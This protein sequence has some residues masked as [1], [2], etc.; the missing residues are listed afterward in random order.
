MLASIRRWNSGAPLGELDSSAVTLSLLW[1]N[2]AGVS[3][4]AEA[5]TQ[6]YPSIHQA[7][8]ATCCSGTHSQAK[9]NI[10]KVKR[11]FA[12][13]HALLSWAT[14]QRH[15]EHHEEKLGGSQRFS[16]EHSHQFILSNK[17]TFVPTF[18]FFFSQI[19][20]EAF[21]RYEGYKYRVARSPE[22]QKTKMPTA[23]E[24]DGD[25]SRAFRKNTKKINT[26]SSKK[27]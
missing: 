16:S 18:F 26:D 13:L 9:L 25:C 21:L 19:F 7:S 11:A 8:S 14:V 10:D 20:H 24:T 3:G 12:Q 6:L 17:R 4:E 27:M 22:R 15:S 23:A 5:G 2:E 1:E